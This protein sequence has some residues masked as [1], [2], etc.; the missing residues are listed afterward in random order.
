MNITVAIEF[1]LGS[2]LAL[3]AGTAAAADFADITVISSLDFGT[4]QSGGSLSA[5]L[6]TCVASA[7]T[8]NPNPRGSAN[9]FAYII[10]VDSLDG[11]GFT[12]YKDGNNSYT[13]DQAISIGF[14]HR[15]ILG[16]TAYETLQPGIYDQHLHDGLF[17]NCTG[18]GSNSEFR[19]SINQSE[20]AQKQDG[21]YEGQFRATILGGESGVASDFED[22]AVSLTISGNTGSN[23][24][25]IS[26]LNDA[27]FAPF[28]GSGDRFWNEHFCIYSG[29]AS[30]AYRLTV[31]S[32]NQDS[33]GV[34][35]LK[36]ASIAEYLPFTVAFEDSGVGTAISPLGGNPVSGLG[37]SSSEDCS[38]VDNATLTFGVSEQDMA[39]ASSGF[40]NDTL[41]LVVEPE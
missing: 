27:A 31:S 12:L 35:R 14:E 6:S 25:K 3:V 21:V 26:R 15:D 13:G 39:Q 1:A 8:N 2:L 28:A 10:K 23:S 5:T 20:L 18:S 36:H 7:D 41:V 22:F 9:N 29:A 4:W 33:S 16:Q 32:L 17:K 37:D 38:G 11:P 40:Y 24:V 19:I 34:F 30:G